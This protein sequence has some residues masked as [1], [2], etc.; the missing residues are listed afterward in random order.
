MAQSYRF[1]AVE[2]RPSERQLLVKGQPAPVGARAF[3][4]LLAL[5]DN[6]DRVVTKDELMDMVWPGLVVEEN[7]LQVQ[8]STL[9][10]ILGS[11]AVATIPGRGYR[12]TL[13]PEGMPEAPSS[14]LPAR[15][16]NLP[17]ALNSFIGREREIAE[18]KELLGSS[19]LVTL[20]STGGTGKTRLSLQVAEDLVE[21]FPDGVWLVELAPVADT[22][23]LAQVVAF[24][25]D[26]KEEP[27]QAGIETLAAYVRDRK[28]LLILDNCEHMLQACA[29]MAKRLLQ[30]GAGVKILAS[31]RERLTIAGETSY[32]V[33][34]L[35]LPEAGAPLGLEALARIDSV[36]L[37][38]NRATAVLPSFRLT[39]QNAPTV[40]E[41]CRRLD[42]IP[43]AIE[44]AAARVHS[45]ALEDISRR[46]GECLAVLTGGD[47]TALP[48]QQTLRA[49]IDWSYELLGEGERTV[50]RRL[51]VFSGGWTLSAA[52]A[53]AN[54]DR[55]EEAT[56]EA[57]SRLVE[58][59][60]VERDSGGTRYRLLE[61]VRQYAQEKLVAANETGG[62][63]AR[64]LDYF[65]ALAES[66]R[67]HLYGPS[68]AAWLAQLDAEREN[69]VAAHAWC[70]EAARGAELGLRLATSMKHYWCN[71]GLPSLAYR[72]AAQ[73]L[74]RGGAQ[75]RDAMRCRV[76]F[77]AGQVAYLMGRYRE[78]REHLIESLAIARSLAD[79]VRIA[80][81]L[82]PLGLAY[83]AEKDFDSAR[84]RIEEALALVQ[85]LGDKRNIASALNA[86]AQLHRAQGNAPAAEPLYD[87]AL[88]LFR[89]VGDHESVA[90]ALLNLA[91]TFIERGAPEAAR[92]ACLEALEVVEQTG[93]R[94]TGQSV[95]EV[96][97]GLAAAR[98]DWQR[99][100]QLYGAA[101]AQQAQSNLRRSPPDE[102]F[103]RPR[104]DETRRA[105]GDKR[106]S[107]EEAAGRASSY[108]AMIAH[109]RAW[110]TTGSR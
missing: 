11:Q 9:R 38:L 13:V 95:L 10:K 88:A 67:P 105:L 8:V 41:I 57:L 54:P 63:R 53:V 39:E 109:A 31:S 16:H 86:L 44:L 5:I 85:G 110:L 42:G 49:S 19:R 25:L 72:M 28:L 80:A 96:A 93:S 4:V 78:S 87:D 74:S 6:R 45:L 90:V 100:A 58:K 108:D 102:A 83:L 98:G 23:R 92:S 29:E 48:R 37:F 50:F 64:H 1:G 14:P 104:I 34:A 24:V 27:G 12:F 52:H 103:L 82:Q 22:A 84:E 26:V 70:D 65:L 91:M 33:A 56:I 69:F 59:S 68:Q 35:A 15:R 101:E 46:L 60:L 76:L 2:V 99:A 30:A 47:V 3:D 81:A 107:E 71:R 61:T 43:L 20:T 36:R 66:A 77:D 40:V 18:I 79:K 51:A 17:A 32:P 75:A 106:F 73:A 97:A 55:A 89:E 7:N 21:E 94:R 62:T